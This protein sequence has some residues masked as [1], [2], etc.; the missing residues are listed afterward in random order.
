MVNKR[1]CILSLVLAASAPGQTIEGTVRNVLTGAGIAGAKVALQ[2]GQAPAY[3]ATADANGRFRIEEVKDGTYSVQYTA[4]GYFSSHRIPPIQVL[5]GA[6]P[7]RIEGRLAPLARI[8]GRV[9]DPSGQAVP[10]AF[11]EL[12]TLQTFFTA[13]TDSKGRFSIDSVIPGQTNYTLRVEPPPAGKPPEPAGRP[14]AWAST[15]Y[16]AAAR[17]EQASPIVL[18]AGSD[19]QGLEIKLLAVPTH[20]VRGVLLNRGGSPAP[21]VSIALWETGSRRRAAYHAE[22]NANGAFEFPAVGEG[23]WRLHAESKDQD[24][25]LRTDEW[26]DVRGRDLE[27]LKVRLAAPFTVSGRVMLEHADGQAAPSAPPVRLFRVHG[28]Q[29]LFADQSVFTEQPGVDGRVRFEGLYPGS[30]VIQPAG[31]PPQ[32]YYLDSIQQG[33]SLVGD[34]VEIAAD[35]PEF[36]ITYK[37]HGGTVRGSVEKCDSGQVLLVRQNGPRSTLVADCDVNG[38]FQISAVRPGDYYAVAVPD[39]ALRPGDAALVQMAARAAVRAGEITQ[40]DLSLFTAR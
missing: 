28:G 30:Y 19:V 34:G 17:R 25:T 4:D 18:S 38:R 22:S 13:R 35:S 40:L 39:Y 12:A 16:P 10:D 27:G 23:E 6:A 36:A 24:A 15:F 29:V 11:V 1:L 21:K 20:A 9:V 7:A 33:N 26:I 14:R 5:A 8:S 37:T 2:Q 31:A 32:D 3:S